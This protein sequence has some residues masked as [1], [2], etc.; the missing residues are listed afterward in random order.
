MVA[1]KTT[2]DFVKSAKER[3]G[4]RYDYS[5]SEYSASESKVRIVCREHGPF[6]QKPRSHCRGD[7]CPKCGGVYRPTQEEFIDRV[8]SVHG[9]RYGYE[10]TVY[11]NNKSRITAECSDHGKFEMIAS[12]FIRGYGCQYCSGKKY[13]T[14]S[15]IARARETH[16]EIYD[17]SRTKFIRM[18]KKI[19]V[20][21]RDHGEFEQEASSHA[22]GA[23]CPSCAGYGYKRTEPAYLY[24]LKSKDCAFLKVGITA[25][26]KTRMVKLANAT[27]FEFTLH[28]KIF[29]DGGM[30]HDKEM[31]IQS[32]F[33]SAGLSGFD[34][35]T[36]WLR[37]DED[38]VSIFEQSPSV[39]FRAEAWLPLAST[40][41]HQPLLPC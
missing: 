17:Y 35:C 21:C 31:E 10:E 27:P 34:G 37:Y 14:V 40:Q 7:G 28:R 18:D 36:E 3:H 2:A 16:G 19:V 26:I 5:L 24:C 12:D 29:T 25:D 8:K 30:A 15:F 1:R 9:E 13:N 4:D 6:L 11:I 20:T 38:I 33:M 41:K 32:R 39:V 22:R 23:G